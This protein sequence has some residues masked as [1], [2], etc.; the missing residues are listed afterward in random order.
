MDQQ[1]MS[2]TKLPEVL[3]SV[4]RGETSFADHASDLMPFV[5]TF[6][7]RLV[8]VGILALVLLVWNLLAWR[9]RRNAAVDTSGP[10][11]S[12]IKRWAKRILQSKRLLIVVNAVCIFLIASVIS[13]TLFFRPFV[14]QSTPVYGSIMPSSETP[15]FVEFDIPVKE[16]DIEFHISPDVPG[17]WTFKRIVPSLPYSRKAVFHPQESFYPESEVVVYIVGIES[18]STVGKSHEHALEFKAPAIPKVELFTPSNGSGDVPT[19]ADIVIDYNAPLGKYVSFTVEIEPPAEYRVLNNDSTQRIDFPQGLL[20]DEEYTVRVYE[21]PRS[22]DVS[23]NDDLSVGDTEMVAET[24]FRTVTTPLVESYEPKGENALPDNELVVVFDQRMDRESVES[25]F[26]VEPTVNGVMTWRDERTFVFTPTENLPK[27]TAFEMKFSKGMVSVASGATSKDIVLPFRTIGPV[28]VST[29]SPVSGSSGLNPLSTEI[30][31]A[32]NQEVDHASAQEHIVINPQPAG[33]FIWDGTTVRYQVSGSLSYS[34]RYTV[35]VTAGIKSVHGMDS[36]EEFMAEFTTKA[37]I[38]S[39]S[40]PWYKQQE[41]F[42]CNVAAARMVLAYRGVYLSE[43]QVRS[44]IGIGGDPNQSWVPRYGVHAG[45]VASFI[46]RY[47]TAVV[48]QGWDVVSLAKEV[49]AGNPVIVWWYNRYSQ[50]PGAYT[51]ESGATGYMGM[52]SEVVKGFI[53][54]SDD[55]QSILTNDPWRGPL[56]Y[57]KSLFL[58]TWGYLGYTAVVVY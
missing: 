57:T 13:V 29:I 21:T 22:Y 37:N 31:I 16:S 49:E 9:L 47:R 10:H 27:D 5:P 58:S 20:Q 17:D 24:T 34:T 54:S 38:F 11:V 42:T 48:R 39:L 33:T 51:L 36:V 6:E 45:P 40:V 3:F 53:G 19:T 18:L 8:G 35:R 7:E 44:A 55:P 23:T 14:I 46:G 50:P 43:E 41:T 30:S 1:L 56:T 4:V 28:R 25:H 26:S 15:I 2:I 12:W 32:F 52:H